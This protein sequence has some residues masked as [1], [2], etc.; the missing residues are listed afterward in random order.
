MTKAN[1]P[2]SR[3]INAKPHLRFLIIG[4]N[5]AIVR[6]IKDHLTGFDFVSHRDLNSVNITVYDKVFLFSWSHHSL[7]ENLLL[8]DKLILSRMVLISTVAV[9]ACARRVQWASYPNWKLSCE[10]RVL[11]AGG[12]IIRIGIWENLPGMVPITTI[13]TL[14]E[15][16]FECI[17]TNK[18][19]FW[20]VTLQPGC[21]SGLKL[22][23]SKLLS[24]L[25]FVFPAQLLFQA[26]IIFLSKFLGTKD[27]GYT[28]DCL[29]FFSNRALV[30]FGAVGSA[31]SR[32][33]K[34]RG[35]HHAIVVSM[36][37]NQF[38]NVDGFRGLRIGQYKE[39][40]SRLWHGVWIT[41]KSNGIFHKNVPLLVARP[42][43][44]PGAIYGRATHL[45][46]S[47]PTPSVV[48]DHPKV[49]DM[50]I[51]ADVIHLAAGVVNNVKILQANHK[52]AATFSDHEIGELGI[53]ETQELVT[54]GIITR[55]FGIVAGRKVLKGQYGNIEYILD[56]RPKGPDSI[57]FDAENIYKNPMVRI[58]SKL[59]RASSF[60]LINQAFFNK[61]GFSLDVCWFSTVIQ[62]ESPDCIKLSK[63][64]KLTRVRLT[65]ST[66]ENI[67]NE[68][69]GDFR[70]FCKASNPQTFDAIH[71]HGGFDITEFPC[72]QGLLS[73][74]RLFIH[75]NVF[76]GRP[77]GPFHNTIPMIKRELE[78]I[79]DA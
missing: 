2:N 16:I 6:E 41:E 51:F 56:F 49:N 60:R 58:V 3:I 19:V 11:K 75:G 27:Y 43:L 18:R 76:D 7:E 61:F 47:L 74:K 31:V 30:G 35:L 53:I 33:L 10:N 17:E 64:G 12:Q 69:A 57:K 52:I 65:S 8:L 14:L 26:P 42:K 37:E 28:H 72:I 38:L 62:I 78:V 55:R 20:P 77:L 34:Q 71:I 79:A 29:Q 46:F 40:L 9:L 70:T 73:R 5:S 45:D 32:A 48:I 13:H 63:D 67:T 4:K 25:T 39:G 59:L 23:V 44:P 1:G 21:L 24:G 22:I 15:A 68:I 54:K 66:I 36:D 50:R